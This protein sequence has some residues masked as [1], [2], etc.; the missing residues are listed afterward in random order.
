MS[1][2]PFLTVRLLIVVNVRFI[3]LSAYRRVMFELMTPS[4]ASALRVMV[5]E[6]PVTLLMVSLTGPQAYS[7]SGVKVMVLPS[8]TPVKVT[9]PALYTRFW[10]VF[11]YPSAPGWERTT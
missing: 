8:V 7:W 9:S 2:F 1:V 3:V 10:V 6:P 4:S 5:W 11:L